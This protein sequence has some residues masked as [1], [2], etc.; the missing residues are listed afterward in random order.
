MVGSL[1]IRSYER[2]ERIYNAMVAR[3]YAGEIRTL[4]EPSLRAADLGMG[5]LFVLILAGIQA[6][7]WLL[8]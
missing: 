2:S 4:T 1:F 6:I 3:G 5:V 7:S 8:V